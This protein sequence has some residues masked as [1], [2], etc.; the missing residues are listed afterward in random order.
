MDMMHVTTTCMTN[1][2]HDNNR[3]KTQL[4]IATRTSSKFSKTGTNYL[5]KKRKDEGEND[6]SGT[7]MANSA[8]TLSK[9]YQLSPLGCEGI[10]ILNRS[11]QELH[12]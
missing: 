11:I 6:S 3:K 12:E 4:R 2:G 8:L 5:H 10:H 7:P 1:A 9:M